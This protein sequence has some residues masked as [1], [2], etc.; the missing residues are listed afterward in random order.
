[1]FFFSFCFFSMLT[2]PGPERTESSCGPS[3]PNCQKPLDLQ[4]F[5]LF[6]HPGSPT[7]LVHLLPWRGPSSVAGTHCHPPN[8]SLISAMADILSPSSDVCATDERLQVYTGYKYKLFSSAPR[9]RA[10]P[11]RLLP[12]FR[13]WLTFIFRFIAAVW[14]MVQCSTLTSLIMT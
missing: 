1:M 2:I 10:M 14:Y 13:P 4:G 11:L 7:T 12:S 5:Y 6:P 3:R 9:R 8:P